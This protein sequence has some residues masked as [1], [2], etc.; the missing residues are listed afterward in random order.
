MMIKNILKNKKSIV[1]FFISFLTIIILLL[2][3]VNVVK[4]K[5]LEK[6]EPEVTTSFFIK[7][8]DNLY[9]M[10]NEKGKKL[11]DFIY[12][13]VDTIF[14]GSVRV[15]TKD[16]KY[17]ILNEKGKYLV[18][19][20]KYDTIY[21]YGG[22]FKV[23]KDDT[24]KLV[25]KKNKKVIK[26]NDFEVETITNVDDFVIVVEKEEYV[27]MNYNGKKIVSFK[28]NKDNTDL[29][30]AS[31]IDDYASVYYDGLT[32]VF[33]V[34]TGKILKKIKDDVHYCINSVSEDEKMLSLNSCVSWY[35][36]LDDVKYKLLINKKVK[37]LPEDCNK[38]TIKDKVLSCTTDE[39][40]YLLDNK[41]KLTDIV[42]SDIS[43]KDSKN[44]ARKKDTDVEFIKNG[45]VV[46]TLKN[47]ILSDK[48]YTKDGIYL[49][50]QD[51][52][53]T[54]YD[55]KGKKLFKKDFV[56]A[57][58]FDEMGLARVSDDEEN[59]YFIN[60]KGKKVGED[61][62]LS[63]LSKE[64]YIVTKDDKKGI[65]N[66]KGKMLIDFTYDDIEIK[67]YNDEYYAEVKKGDEYKVICLKDKKEVLKTSVQPIFYDHYIKVV[68]ED[69][70]TY[71][72][73]TGKKL[74]EE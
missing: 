2:V 35:E 6:Q 8:S 19:L 28:I 10:F 61:F 9:A 30:T 21:Q 11:T 66:P 25:N 17:G 52:K 65:M 38:I 29:P 41:Y 56:M 12:S 34:K 33:N 50:Y 73:Y 23:K 5:N 22:L 3:I 70:T 58:S 43:Y 45:K 67:T 68:E 48:G 54:Y 1:N 18:K 63:Y 64:H 27:V 20:E 62:E 31:E 72:T 53:Y 37:D 69:K 32:Y 39:G 24:N 55:I 13:S 4:N 47:A 36:T 71:Y 7:N 59:Y 14:N 16:G 49:V 40:T 74:Y 42:V 15:K 60:I 57:T 44:Y 46:K 51:N 26:E